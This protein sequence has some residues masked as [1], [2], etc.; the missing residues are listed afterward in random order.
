MGYS[1]HQFKLVPIPAVRSNTEIPNV[2]HEFHRGEESFT[3]FESNHLMT[4]C[5]TACSNPDK[6]SHSWGENR[7]III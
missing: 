5:H 4:F 7:F 2:L 6:V 3:S 1:R